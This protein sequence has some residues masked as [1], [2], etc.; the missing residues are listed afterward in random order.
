MVI[1]NEK[2]LPKYRRSK[3]PYSIVIKDR[4]RRSVRILRKKP[5]AKNIS[6]DQLWSLTDSE[7]KIRLTDI[8]FRCGAKPNS[9]FERGGKH[10]PSK[11]TLCNTPTNVID[12]LD[13]N[14]P[15]TWENT[16]TLCD[17]CNQI[18][19]AFENRGQTFSEDKMHRHLKK[20][21]KLKQKK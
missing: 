18:K 14:K 8:C 6:N 9:L 5:W 13:N 1:E 19:M 17:T 3:N 11:W 16:N 7:S 10:L 2:Y 15:Y 21:V 20:M 12:R 4:K